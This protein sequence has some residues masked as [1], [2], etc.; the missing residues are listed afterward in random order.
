[1]GTHVR[2][3][4]FKIKKKKNLKKKKKDYICLNE[5]RDRIAVTLTQVVFVFAV[6]FVVFVSCNCWKVFLHTKLNFSSMF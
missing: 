6:F 2:I 1:M 4:D 3:K 5:T